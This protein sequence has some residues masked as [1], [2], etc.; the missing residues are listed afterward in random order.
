MPLKTVTCCICNKTV[1]KR[2]TLLLVD[3]RACRT[4]PE[5]VQFFEVQKQE[6]D[7]KAQEANKKEQEAARW[8]E[9]ERQ[10]RI[11]SL[12]SGVQVMHT[13]Q[14]IPAEF[15]YRRI[16]TVYGPEMESDVRSEIDKRDGPRMSDSEVTN[17]IMMAAELRAR[18]KL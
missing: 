8:A 15:L 9:A 11:L 13:M 17:S 14:G 7:K 4:H 16:R 5:V 18:G 6:A 10:M 2:S 3:K 1:S 12:V